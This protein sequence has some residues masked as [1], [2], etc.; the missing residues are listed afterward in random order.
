MA[1][2]DAYLREV[3][4][5]LPFGAT[6]R[7]DI[8]EEL[9]AHLD[10]TALGLTLDG[11]APDD[12]ERLALGRLGPPDRLAAELTRARRTPGRLLVAAGVGTWTVLRTGVYGLLLGALVVSL[13]GMA[14]WIAA[15]AGLGKGTILGSSYNG[16]MSLVAG[17]LAAYIAGRGVTP[18][19]AERAGYSV[20]IARRATAAVGAVILAAWALTGRSGPLDAP[21]VALLLSL[22]AWFI[23]GAWHG[24]RFPASGRELV[25]PLIGMTVGTF[26]LALGFAFTGHLQ[27]GASVGPGSTEYGVDRIGRAA[28]DA[29]LS[30]IVAS[31]V[32]PAS[33]ADSRASTYSLAFY[34]PAVLDGWSDLR[35]EAWRAG[36]PA[37]PDPGPGGVDPNATGPFVTAPVAWDPA[38]SSIAPDVAA[39]VDPR[40]ATYGTVL[41]GSLDL[42]RWPGVQ[43]AWVAITGVA[44]DGTRRTISG[45]EYTETTFA[46]TALDWLAAV[47]A[48]R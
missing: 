30:A 27:V 26:I 13:A 36:L 33:T 48:G 22:P 7:A 34:D 38:G 18:A 1:D 2:R 4:D 28:P 21:M 15:G 11:H 31:G 8:L 10:D 6:E 43:A 19:V 45:P 9:G 47:A 29:V 32:V 20:G 24:Q 37:G 46:G 35:I 16:A 3:A 44:R 5:R 17:G 23:A 41:S 39:G 42:Q 40:W 14:L 12:A 25:R